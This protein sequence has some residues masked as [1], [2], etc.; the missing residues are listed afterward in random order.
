MPSSRV[1]LS[2]EMLLTAIGDRWSPGEV[3]AAAELLAGGDGQFP[4]GIRSLPPD[5][6]SA[7]QRERLLAAALRATAELGYREMNVQ[8][9]L[10]RSGVSRP[11]FY[12]HFENKE[13]CFL[14]ALDA[15]GGRLRTR[16]VA[17]TG[18]ADGNWR[19]RLRAA[20]EELLRFAADEPD[21]AATLVVEARAACPAALLRRDELL[22][23]FAS[24]LD[25]QI[26]ADPPKGSPPSAIA[27]AGVVGGIDALLYSRLNR[28]EVENLEELLPS[29][30]Y[31]A[32]L[33]FEGQQVASEELA[34]PVG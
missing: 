27:S 3:N 1:Q 19:D 9:V 28:E 2:H 30:M 8:D 16:I 20:L 7:I 18:S 11:T 22:D 4:S 10:D 26:R 14:A 12:E 33:P 21:A 6:V 25:A 13:A 5:L 23:H 17:T 34:L 29:L 15:A 32:V 24:C 31:F